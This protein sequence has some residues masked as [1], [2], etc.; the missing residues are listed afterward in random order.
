M[1]DNTAS[2]HGDR[3]SNYYL[4][5]YNQEYDLFLE[6]QELE[7]NIGI[8]NMG[9]R[10]HINLVKRFESIRH[11]DQQLFLNYFEV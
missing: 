11:D 4:N 6:S 5:H 8:N 1:L 2:A 10:R 3:L 9:Y 7:L